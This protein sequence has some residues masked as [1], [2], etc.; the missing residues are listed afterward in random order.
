MQ[1][2]SVSN[3]VLLRK[4]FLPPLCFRPPTRGTATASCWCSRRGRRP[5][6]AR[7]STSSRG[8]SRAACRCSPCWR[9]SPA[10]TGPTRSRGRGDRATASSAAPGSPCACSTPPSRC[11]R[12]GRSLTLMACTFICK[13]FRE[14]WLTLALGRVHATSYLQFCF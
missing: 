1:A 2:G 8:R 11:V 10:P 14:S 5:T 7:S 12:E 6:G 4:S 9:A 3:R 13:R